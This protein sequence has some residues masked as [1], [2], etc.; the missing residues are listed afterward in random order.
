MTCYFIHQSSNSFFSNCSHDICTIRYTLPFLSVNVQLVIF[1][2]N[3]RKFI[4]RQI[5][6]DPCTETVTRNVR[7][8]PESV[9]VNR[10]KNILKP[11]VDFL[12]IISSHWFE[13]YMVKH[14]MRTLQKQDKL[15]MK[16]QHNVKRQAANRMKNSFLWRTIAIYGTMH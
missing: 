12:D 6:N 10:K 2:M 13:N 7:H 9:P 3:G 11:N 14:D 5:I 1:R 4:F 16:V 8:C 15:I